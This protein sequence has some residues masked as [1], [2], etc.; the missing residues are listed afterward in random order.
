MDYSLIIYPIMPIII[1][2]GLMIGVLKMR[3]NAIL[4]RYIDDQSGATAVEFGLLALP[5]FMLLVGIFEL[6][7]FYA[8]GVILEGAANGASRMIRTGQAQN[9]GNP[10]AAFEA[11]MCDQV[12]VLVNCAD[13]V[14]DAVSYGDSFDGVANASFELDED[15]NMISAG[16]DAGGSNEVI[17]VRLAYSHEFFF[18]FMAQILSDG[19]RQN[20]SMHMSTVVLRTEPYEF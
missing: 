4:A 10:Q 3:K 20:A 7:M 18:P 16:F 6:S 11:E 8:S 5:F 1:S 14:Y 13:I 12:G 9:S 2:W 17:M 19:T 15:G